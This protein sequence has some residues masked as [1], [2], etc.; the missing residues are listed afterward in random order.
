MAGPPDPTDPI[1]D[2]YGMS[3]Q[4][5]VVEYE[6]LLD[7]L[8]VLAQG[9]ATSRDLRA[10]FRALTEFVLVSTPSSGLFASI[11]NAELRQRTA[12]FAWSDGE[13]VDVS[14]LPPM[15]M[16]DSPHSRA[17]ATGQIIVTGDFQAAM[18]GQP[19]VHV[20]LD[21]DPRLPAS[22]VAVPMMVLGRVIGGF[23]AQSLEPHAYTHEHIT[24]MRMA[25][26][27]AAISMENVQLIEEERHLRLVAEAS[28][29]RAAATTRELDRALAQ[30]DLLNL[31]SI[32]AAGEDDLERILSAA[33][34]RLGSVLTFT[35]GSIALV[36]GQD[37]VITAAVGPF[38]GEALGQRL[39]KGRG[40][41]WQVVLTKE[42][43]LAGDLIT[44]KLRST[45]PV[46][47]YLAVPLVW[48][49]EAFGL[50][51]VDS[52]EPNAFGQADVELMEKVASA[53]SGPIELAQRYAAEVRATGEA[54]AA[55][56]MRDEMLSVVSH[57]L[58]NPLAVIKGSVQLLRKRTTEGKVVSSRLLSPGL[59]RIDTVAGKMIILIN[60]LMDFAQLQ[61]G[62]P[63]NLVRRQTDLVA[64]ARQ[65]AAQ[66]QQTTARNTISVVTDLPELVGLWDAFR[67]ERVLD[68]L[69]ANAVKFSPSGGP[70]TVNVRREVAADGAEWAVV[71]VR[72]EGVGIP[73]A[74]LPYVFEWFRRAENSSG[75]IRGAGIGLASSKHAVE[76]HGGTLTAES[77]EGKYSVFT[78]RLPLGGEQ[79]AQVGV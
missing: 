18:Q 58:K 44:Q 73:Q 54:E 56:R 4:N 3:I 55:V 28:E 52:I 74:D 72:D 67:V 33:L 2:V 9:L 31:V 36:E 51:E 32:A 42:P 47:S 40:R 59:E 24:A 71:S 43:F 26:N 35:G 64:M 50:L 10:V 7:R 30:A 78:M 13:E 21:R 77:K 75:V 69:L 15:P 37:L 14:T 12:I 48:R 66:H 5:A 38:A 68:N 79:E 70:V 53:L 60:E 45:S 17:V 63:L 57:D 76:Q 62:Q 27:L 65:V 61:V 20:G 46:R 19:V 11:Y 1:D 8:A 22:S 16:S 6:Q 49:G 23:E 41:S 39:P 29:Q 34:D 25:A